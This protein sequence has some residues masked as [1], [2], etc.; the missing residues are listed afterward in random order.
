MV[1][2]QGAIAV[3]DHHDMAMVPF[4]KR[5]IVAEGLEDAAANHDR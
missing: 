2:P 3:T 1:N 5:A 4:V